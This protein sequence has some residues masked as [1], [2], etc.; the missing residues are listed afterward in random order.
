MAQNHFQLGGERAVVEKPTQKSGMYEVN[1]IDRVNAKVDALTQKI[2]SLT[3][4]PVATI[5]A[6]TPNCKLCGTPGHTNA[7]CQ[8]LVGF[9]TDQIRKSNFLVYIFL[10]RTISQKHKNATLN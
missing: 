8:L 1:G 10:N 3:I 4:T 5:A 6:V 7:D 9:P 2:E